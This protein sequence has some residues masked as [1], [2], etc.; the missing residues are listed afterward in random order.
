MSC[1]E[2]YYYQDDAIR[3]ESDN[4]YYPESCHEDYD[5]YYDEEFGAYYHIDDMHKVQNSDGIVWHYHEDHCVKLF[6]P[7]SLG[8]EWAY[9]EDAIEL[10]DGDIVHKNDLIELG[11]I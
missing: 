11:Y 7:C 2:E 10:P 1:I 8:Y 9:H 5:V 6:I 3:C 4:E